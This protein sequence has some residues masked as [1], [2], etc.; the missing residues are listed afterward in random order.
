MG[1]RSMNSGEDAHKPRQEN[2]HR[3]R[4]LSDRPGL[5]ARPVVRSCVTRSRNTTSLGFRFLIRKMGTILLPSGA[6]LGS[7]GNDVSECVRF[8]MQQDLKNGGPT[9]SSAIT[10]EHGWP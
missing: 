8:A 1:P 10:R 9:A 3:R 6:A 5:G 4:G 7:Q 2:Q